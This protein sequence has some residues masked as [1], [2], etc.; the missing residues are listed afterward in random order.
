MKID[1]QGM[2]Y[3]T[4]KGDSGLT[5]EEQRAKIPPFNPPKLNIITDALKIELKDLIN[6]VLDEREHQKQLNGPYDFF[7]DDDETEN[8]D[9]GTY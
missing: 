8:T 7:E 1:T 4:G 3:D 6:E 9:W 2:S 5:L